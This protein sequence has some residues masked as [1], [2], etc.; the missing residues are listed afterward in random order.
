MRIALLIAA[1]LLIA[2][3]SPSPTGPAKR[4]GSSA[5]S[6]AAA[7]SPAPN[8]PNAP[9]QGGSITDI[10]SWIEAGHPA[11][12]AHYHSATR[13]GVRTELGADIAFS[14]DTVTCMTSVQ[15]T[16]ALV[17]LIDLANP[18]PP[19]ATSYGAWKGG[20]VDFDGV[21]LQIGSAHADPG[22]FLSGK[23]TELARG[24]ALSFGDFRCRSDPGGVF[25][26]NYAHRSAVRLAG[27]G[28][29]TFGCLRPVSPPDGVGQQFSCSS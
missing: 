16:G 8:A 28:I 15:H 4:T 25:C 27:A 23:G 20:W 6:T 11:D 24:D 9:K 26:V 18:P 21:S 22:P 3:C 2:G 17:C 14:A 7:S 12:V 29:A 5:P 1:S 19:P 10:T 13:D